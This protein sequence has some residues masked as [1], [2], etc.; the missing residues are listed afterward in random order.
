MDLLERTKEICHLYNINPSRSK[1]QNF[2]VNEKV[3]DEIVAAANLT[4]DDTVLEVGPGLGILTAKLAEKAGRVIAVELDDKLAK[5]LQDG[6]KNSDVD[7][8]EVINENILDFDVKR[9]FSVKSPI[10]PVLLPTPFGRA[11]GRPSRYPPRHARGVPPLQGGEYKVVANLPYNITSVFIRKFL[12]SENKP[13]EMVLMLQKEVAERIC[14]KP[15]DM[16]LL[17][18]SVQFF[19]VPE[20]IAKVPKEDFYP[21][22]QV[23]SAIIKLKVKKSPLERGGSR[24]ARRGVLK[25]DGQGDAGVASGALTK[26][27]AESAE[28]DSAEAN[29][30]RLAKFGFSAKRKML[31]NNLAGGLHVTPAEAEK[32]LVKAGFNPKA[33][34]EDLSVEDWKKLAQLIARNT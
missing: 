19:A 33:R 30:F 1:G 25:G 31:K 32:I 34:A 7:N 11:Q 13:S 8:I 6:L 23:D 16:S 20:I 21:S 26:L 22:P 9:I 28:R 18:L 12:T 15:G 3:Y 27:A 24:L 17:A 10:H 4:K 29:F 2:L 5:Y 14:A